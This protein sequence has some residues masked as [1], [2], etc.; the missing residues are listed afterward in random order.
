VLNLILDIYSIQGNHVACVNIPHEEQF[1]QVETTHPPL[2]CTTKSKFLNTVL[3]Q[4]NNMNIQFLTTCIM[5]ITADETFCPW[6]GSGSLPKRLNYSLQM[7]VLHNFITSTNQQWT[8]YLLMKWTTQPRT[9]DLS[10][11]MMWQI[12]DQVTL[13]WCFIPLIYI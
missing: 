6:K 9:A 7:F 13:L 11:H 1:F 10:S 3:H 5:T 12:A 8:Q 4:D 2:H